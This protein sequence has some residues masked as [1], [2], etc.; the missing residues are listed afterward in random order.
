MMKK[1]TTST[2]KRM[3]KQGE[4]IT[5]LTAYDY[6][7]AVALE[8]AE[9]EMLLVGDSLGMVVLGYEDTTKVTMEDM[10][11]HTKAVVRGASKPL[12]VADLPFLSY[13]IDLGETVR[14]A[15]RLIQEG[16]AGAVK[17][18]GGVEVVAQVKAIT[19]AGIP[20]MGHIGLTPQSIHQMG[21]YYIQGKTEESANKLLKEAK[22]LEE[23]G[24]F[25]I[26]LEC[27]PEEVAS[28]IT[29]HVT[30]PTIGIG[31][32]KGC[33]GQVLVSHDLLGLYPRS[34]PKFVK[35]YTELK[36]TIVSAGQA[37]RQEVKEGQFPAEEHTFYL[38]GEVATKLYGGGSTSENI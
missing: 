31:A 3:K 1:I 20:V 28:Y 5:M 24:A 35:Q 25:A 15:G 33:D 10:V 22:A 17:L 29:Q 27:V 23:A 37:Y 34:V 6:P 18:E 36:E 7:T 13:H 19:N 38:K 30:V 32:G 12:I 9:I 26:V 11:H 2:V 14:N 4:K 8:E 16:G 21:G